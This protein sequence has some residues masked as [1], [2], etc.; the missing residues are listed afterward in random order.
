MAGDLFELL[1]PCSSR[2]VLWVPIL[3]FLCSLLYLNFAQEAPDFSYFIFFFLALW[4][5]QLKTFPRSAL[6]AANFYPCGGYI[7]T[8]LALKIHLTFSKKMRPFYCF[9]RVRVHFRIY[10]QSSALWKQGS[11]PL[12]LKSTV[13]SGLVSHSVQS[14]AEV[15]TSREWCD[16]WVPPRRMTVR[17]RDLLVFKLAY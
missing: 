13:G 4:K 16:L 2:W 6:G 7:L 17:V 10:G 12:N 14:F 15:N 3:H 9:P 1:C 8:L 5:S 11:I